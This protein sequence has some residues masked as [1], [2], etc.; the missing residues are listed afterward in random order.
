KIP[1]NFELMTGN[2]RYEYIARLQGK[3][4]WEDLQPIVLTARG[5]PKNPIV[6]KG[7]DPER[8]IACTGFPADS[9]EA[10]WLTIRDHGKRFDRC[11]HCGNVFKYNQ[12][13]AHH[14]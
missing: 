13:H 4:P 12:E 3:D 6:I 5:T 2:E 9:H 8:Y 7:Q 1:T 14:H 10:I 11:P